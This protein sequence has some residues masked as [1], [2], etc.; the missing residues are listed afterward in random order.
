MDIFQKCWDFIEAKE[1]RRTGYYPYFHPLSSAQEPEVVIEG[2]RMIMIG[3]NNYLGLTTHPKVKEAALE[4]VRRF[5]TGCTGSRFLTGTLE[6]HIELE[7]KLAE[8][9]GKETALVFTTGFL[10][11]L[12]TISALVDRRDLLI[13][14]NLDHAS[15]IDGARLSFGRVIKFKHN[16]MQDLARILKEH[17][18]KPKLIVIDGVFSMEGDIAKLPEIV[19]LAKTYKARVMVDDA[20]SIGVL[21]KNG[22]GTAEHFNLMNEV[23][24]IMG[25]FSKS[26]A[27]IG[28]FITG[29]FDVIDYI[30]HKGRAMIF[31]AALP[32]AS[33]AAVSAVLDIIKNEPERR[34]RLWANTKKMQS[35]F[36]NLGFDIGTS[37]TPIIPIIVGDDRLA[38]EMWK[39]LMERG[40]FANPIITPAVPPGRA[41]IRTSYTATHTEEQL[42]CVLEAFRE[43][44]EKLGVI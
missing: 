24:L 10:T 8:F 2:H 12:G 1:A 38:F 13:L 26:F 35:G 20:H 30:K 41:M 17:Q 22:R 3:S 44:G 40:I 7:K 39:Q 31:S 15:I 25:T 21:G 42:N 29:K 14:D 33:I 34:E 4:A 23:D 9:M 36:K 27:S 37:E 43:V 5:G 19:R 28:G 16:D 6:L 18:N 32:P 11:N